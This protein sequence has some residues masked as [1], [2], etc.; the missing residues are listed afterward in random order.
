WGC[1]GIAGPIALGVLAACRADFAAR[2]R[3]ALHLEAGGERVPS[4]CAWSGQVV[5]AMGSGVFLLLD[6]PAMDHLLHAAAPELACEMRPG[7]APAAL[8]PLTTAVAS[9]R[10]PL[11]AR[12]AD[13]E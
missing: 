9:T 3:A 7:T 11:R 10:L 6:A 2:L 4:S 13:C 1:D 5:A 8:T 12:L